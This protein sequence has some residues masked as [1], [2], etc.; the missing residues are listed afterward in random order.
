[1]GHECALR[2]RPE[3]YSSGQ[4]GGIP[5]GYWVDLT[6]LVSRWLGTPAFPGELA[7]FLPGIRYNCLSSAAAWIERRHGADLSA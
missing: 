6:E 5:N 2:R 3:T 4:L 1:V 7:H